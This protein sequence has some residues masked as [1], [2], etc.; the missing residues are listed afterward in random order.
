M[1]MR[2]GS[3]IT[4]PF[5]PPKGMSTTAHFQLIHIES[6]ITSSRLTFGW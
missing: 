6:A 3:Q 4:P 1:L 2:L 5:P